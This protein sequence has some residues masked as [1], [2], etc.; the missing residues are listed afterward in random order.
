MIPARGSFGVVHSHSRVAFAIRA[1]TMSR[2]NHAVIA[3]DASTLIE[4][5]PTGV[6]RKP[7]DEYPP[8][9]IVWSKPP[10]DWQGVQVVRF[11]ESCLGDD[12]NYPGIAALAADHF[13]H[14]RPQWLDDVANKPTTWFCSQLVVAAYR[15]AGID[16]NPG[17]DWICSPGDLAE[18]ILTH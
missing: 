17:P 16:L 12:Y 18:Y 1:A 6:E 3:A 15:H 8:E 4:A 9:S 5:N 14:W 13:L 10:T 2:R 11:A 7:L